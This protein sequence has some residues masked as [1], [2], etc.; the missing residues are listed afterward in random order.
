MKKVILK[1][2]KMKEKMKNMK[3]LIEK[4]KKIIIIIL[5]EN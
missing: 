5:T 3:I 1:I 4:I 2:L